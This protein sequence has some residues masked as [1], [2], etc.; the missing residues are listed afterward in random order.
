[1]ITSCRL[2]TMSKEVKVED[3]AAGTGPA[4]RNAYRGW[5]KSSPTPVATKQEPRFDGR[6][7]AL[8]GFTFDCTE[9]QQTDQYA[10]NMKEI[11]WE[12]NTRTEEI[13]VGP[14]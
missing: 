7:D 6:Y 2:L 10:V 9:G 8:K 1:M 12:G 3:A 14:L 4:K 5:Y 11:Y 13:F